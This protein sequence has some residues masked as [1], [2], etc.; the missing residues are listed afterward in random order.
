MENKYLDDLQCD[1][2]RYI[3][4]PVTVRF[5][6]VEEK[7]LD[8]NHKETGRP[9][10]KRRIREKKVPTYFEFIQICIM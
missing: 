3:K 8:R 6:P 7:S 2:A 9:E 10:S 4:K 5:K 1:S